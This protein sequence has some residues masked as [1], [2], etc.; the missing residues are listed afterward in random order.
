MC[1]GGPNHCRVGHMGSQSFICWLIVVLYW[2]MLMCVLNIYVDITV[3]C[4]MI[5][6]H[7]AAQSILSCYP[8]THSHTQKKIKK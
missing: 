4:I 8:C 2:R 3:A 1:L 6:H 7:V 5:C